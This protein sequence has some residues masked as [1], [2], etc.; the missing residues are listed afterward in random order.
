MSG[1]S[2]GARPCKVPVTGPVQHRGEQNSA[3]IRSRDLM[4]VCLAYSRPGLPHIQKSRDL[5][6]FFFFFDFLF[7]TC[8]RWEARV[9]GAIDP[10][11]ARGD[12]Q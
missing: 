8:R 11:G 5:R 1:L 10:D 6:H 9:G 2:L 7:P 3:R 4:L 12:Q